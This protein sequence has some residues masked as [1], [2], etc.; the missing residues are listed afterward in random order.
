ME[1]LRPRLCRIALIVISIGMS[2]HIVQSLN[3]VTLLGGGEI[4]ED[5]LATALARAPFL[6]AADRGADL[7]LGAGHVPEAVIGD[8]DSVSAGTLAALPAGRVHRVAEQDSTDFGKCL[9]LVSAPL[10][11]AVGFQGARLDH[12][13]AV[14][15]ELAAT[16][17]R[18]CIVLGAVDLVFLCPPQLRLPLAAGTRISL[19]P[20]G[21]V[22]GRSTGLE[23]PLD[24]LDFAP[25]GRIGTSNRATGPVT[26]AVEGPVLVILPRAELDLAIAALAA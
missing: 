26:L 3:P 17:Q 12:A 7:A 6:V 19:F 10:M 22:R 2:R 25:A 11:L 23:W 15:A 16:P 14:M 13:L 20:M 18:R 9:R 21:P 8:L 5:D 24:G 1:M 4:G